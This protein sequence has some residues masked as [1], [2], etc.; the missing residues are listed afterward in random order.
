MLEDVLRSIRAKPEL[1][2]GFDVVQGCWL[3][4]ERACTTWSCVGPGT[5]G[6]NSKVHGTAGAIWERQSLM[7]LERGGVGELRCG[8]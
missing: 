8:H 3:G 2:Q 7:R 1:L 4:R 5:Q 6:V